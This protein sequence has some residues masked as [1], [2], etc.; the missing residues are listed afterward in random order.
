MP[1]L[2]FQLDSARWNKMEVTNDAQT[3]ADQVGTKHDGTAQ[4]AVMGQDWTSFQN[5]L[6]TVGTYYLYY[7]IGR[8]T[9][10]L[11]NTPVNKVQVSVTSNEAGA[12]DVRITQLESLVQSLLV[13]VNT[14]ENPSVVVQP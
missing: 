14:L 12:R 4:Y 10:V 3:N 8:R 2:A 5:R 13:R 7:F 11:K 6:T 1:E 9:N